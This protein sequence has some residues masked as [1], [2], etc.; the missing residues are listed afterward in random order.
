MGLRQKDSSK[1]VMMKKELLKLGL[2]VLALGT[3][4]VGCPEDGTADG[5]VDET[6]MIG[7]LC[8][9]DADC[10]D[11]VCDLGTGTCIAGSDMT[12]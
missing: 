3:F 9:T 2:G 12:A 11:Y 10:G 4:L 1:G 7:D 8:D 5:G 6:P